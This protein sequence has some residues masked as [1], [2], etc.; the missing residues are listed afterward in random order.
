[1]ACLPQACAAIYRRNS[2]WLMACVLEKNAGPGL[3]FTPHA[4]SKQGEG[5]E[6]G[7]GLERRAP[8]LHSA[9]KPLIQGSEK[10]GCVSQSVCPRG[11][12]PFSCQVNSSC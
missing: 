6:A 7:S 2:W 9:F 1:M 10:Y 4:P 5:R 12:G 8:M 3:Y 11:T